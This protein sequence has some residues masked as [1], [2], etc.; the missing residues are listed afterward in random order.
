MI[1]LVVYGTALPQG[2]KSARGVQ[3]RATLPA[4]FGD[5]PR[6]R[7]AGREAGGDA[8]RAWQVT[9]KA[10][11][12]EG[13][14]AFEAWFYLPRPQSAAKRIFAPAK[15]PDASKLLRSVED[16]LTGIIWHDDAQVVDG[17]VHKRFADAGP[18]CAVL[19]ISTIES[20]RQL[21]LRG[22]A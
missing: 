1:R 15:K 16:A 8:A 10:P 6:R 14:I 19:H 17:H 11:L 4:V 3:A 12:L 7:K 9:N 18:P 2:S 5:G 13:P 21:E 22:E 20:L